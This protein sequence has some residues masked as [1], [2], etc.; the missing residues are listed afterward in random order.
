MD[1]P[2]VNLNYNIWATIND[3]SCIYYGC[4]DQDFL[5]YNS[6]ANTNDGSC[7][8]PVIFGCTS[9]L[10]FEFNPNA[11]TYDGSCLTP[12]IWMH[13]SNYL[14]YW[15]YNDELYEIYQPEIVP[16]VDDGSC[17]TPIIYGCTDSNYFKY[18]VTN[19]VSD[20]TSCFTSVIYGCIDSLAFNYNTPVGDVLIDANTD[21]GSCI[22]I[23]EGCLD[24]QPLFTLPGDVYSDVNTQDDSCIPKI[25]GCLDSLSINYTIPIGDPL[26]DVMITEH[27]FLSLKVVWSF[28]CS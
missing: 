10:Y 22:P 4:T 1:V 17:L 19:N 24:T 23:I 28:Q 27:V 21:D 8:T 25:F 11:N 20:T 14:E 2:I 7:I 13:D 5:E 6:N 26:I 9:P 12:F 18:N 15:S 3:G 16:N